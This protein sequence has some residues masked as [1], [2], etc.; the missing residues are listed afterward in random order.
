ML[1]SHPRRCKLSD[2][3]DGGE[4]GDGDGDDGGGCDDD[5]ADDDSDD[6][7]EAEE[8]VEGVEGMKVTFIPHGSVASS[9]R[10]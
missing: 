2:V 1:S 9:R 5:D 3:C 7:E 6:D 10:S 8:E 4:V